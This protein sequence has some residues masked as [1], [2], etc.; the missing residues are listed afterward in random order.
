MKRFLSLF[1]GASLLLTAT[2]AELTGPNEVKFAW[3]PSVTPEVSYRL[4][5]GKMAGGPYTYVIPA[6]NTNASVR[7]P[8]GTWYVIVTSVLGELESDPSNEVEV[9]L[10]PAPAGVLRVVSVVVTTT[11]TLAP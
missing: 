8:P 9:K 7:L 11:T 5:L 6:T 1:V 4:Q 3:D 2:A 10:V